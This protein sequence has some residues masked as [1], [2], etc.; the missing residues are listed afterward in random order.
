MY[1]TPSGGSVVNSLTETERECVSVERVT[2][3]EQR[4]EPEQPRKGQ[5]TVL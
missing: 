5:I 3:Y 2:Q 1:R 4:C